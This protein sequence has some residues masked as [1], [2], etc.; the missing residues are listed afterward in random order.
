V[1][2]A[3]TFRRGLNRVAEPAILFPVTAI[4]L[5]TAIWA[6]T[7]G[8]IKLKHSDA[9]HA[10]S[11]SSRELLGTYEAQVARALHEID[12]SMN[13]VKYWHE[14]GREHGALAELRDNGLL[15]PDLLFG[16]SIA[17]RQGTVTDSTRATQGHDVANEDY[18]RK[19]R[20]SDRF[21]V[22]QPPRDSAVDKNLYF[23]RRMNA[24]DGAFDGVVVVAVDAAYFVS[25]YE[26][27]KLGEHGVLGIVGTDGIVRIGRTGES[28]FSG[29]VIDYASVMPGS[30]AVDMDA[31]ISA[32]SWDGVQRW[33][34][35]R[36]IYGFPLAVLVGLSVDEQ[37]A[38]ANRE[39]LSYL[40]RA[41]FGSILV[42]VLTALLGRLSW[43][44][45]QSRIREGETKLANRAKDLFL[46]SM[47]HEIRTP[48][49]GII[50][51]LDVLQQS[52]LIGPQLEL[53]SLIRESADSLL[54]IIDDILDFS[55]IEAGRLDIERLPMSVAQVVEKSCNLVNR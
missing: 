53:V 42:I 33:T 22:G 28:E 21:F 8:L 37:L 7:L 44:L 3:D 15:P 18:F 17:N 30:G 32:G 36:E 27:S 31:T 29:D 11:V 9:E 13:L 48:M 10:A 41:G 19:Q 43:Q 12:Q 47:S 55:K 1:P 51:T 52:S 46:A 2:V 39:T 34:N 49:N 20:E 26:T 14:G 40:R 50:G 5:L 54:T 35:A 6:S 45:A 25:G 38:T 24:A 16:V 23:S 4:L